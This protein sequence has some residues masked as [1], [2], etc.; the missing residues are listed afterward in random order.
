MFPFAKQFSLQF[1]DYEGSQIKRTLPAM[2][3]TGR[4]IL[5]KVRV[6]PKLIPPHARKSNPNQPDFFLFCEKSTGAVQFRT[7]PS[8]DLNC[9][10]ERMAGLLAMQ[11]LVRG[12]D[13]EDF[14]ILVAAEQAF[15]NRL[16]S[17]AKEL[18]EEGRAV[19]SPASLSPRQREILQAVVRNRAN[20]EIASRLNITVRTVKFHISSLLSRFGVQNRAELAR[21]AAGFMQPALLDREEPAEDSGR[22]ALGPVAVN[23]PLHMTTKTRTAQF[24]R[25][26]LSA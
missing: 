12:S 4:P 8:P 22:Q 17:R 19:A 21:R 6:V 20:K 10:V 9:T 3:E 11:C 13:P 25:R 2:G 18:L 16:L 1:S 15:A 24:Q 5:K 23:S 14:D 26:V 7:E